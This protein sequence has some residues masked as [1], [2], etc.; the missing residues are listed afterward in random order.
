MNPLFCN[1]DDND[2]SLAENSPCAETGENGANMG[3]FDV[4]CEPIFNMHVFHVD[5]SGSDETGD[6]TEANPFRTIGHA[7]DFASPNDTVLVAPG[8]YVEYLRFTDETNYVVGSHF[9]TTQDTS[10]ISQTITQQIQQNNQTRSVGCVKKSHG[11]V[12]SKRLP[13]ARSLVQGGE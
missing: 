6:G 13:V 10:Y 3:A 7:K 1:P 11:S 12:G 4:E 2:F 9:L 8:T 5:T